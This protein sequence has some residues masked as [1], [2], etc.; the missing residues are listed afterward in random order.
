MKLSCDL[1]LAPWVDD[2]YTQPSYTAD[3][4]IENFDEEFTS[5]TNF[6][7][8]SSFCSPHLLFFLLLPS[9]HFSPDY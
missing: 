3:K 4:T 1:T 2:F 6:S 7:P 8:C 9:A 5:L